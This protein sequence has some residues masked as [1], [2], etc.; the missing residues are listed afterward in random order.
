LGL[1]REQTYTRVKKT[2]FAGIRTF[3]LISLL[4]FLSA[5]IGQQIDNYWLIGIA[6]LVVSGF[7]MLA[8]YVTQK[9]NKSF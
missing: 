1:E 5:M 2:T 7:V 3:A 9:S 4:G 6:L 8:A